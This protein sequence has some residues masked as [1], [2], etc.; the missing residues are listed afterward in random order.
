MIMCRISRL[1]VVMGMGC[2]KM[3]NRKGIKLSI[4]TKVLQPHPNN[5]QHKPN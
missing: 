4:I 3:M 2:L 1:V 5:L